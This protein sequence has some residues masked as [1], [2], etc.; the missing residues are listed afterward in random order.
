M[1]MILTLL[2]LDHFVRFPEGKAKKHM[3]DVGKNVTEFKKDKRNTYGFLKPETT[4]ATYIVAQMARTNP[5]PVTTA[6]MRKS[7]LLSSSSFLNISIITS[8]NAQ[9]VRVTVRTSLV[10]EHLP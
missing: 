9:D 4:C 5:T 8:K 1:S 3:S 7:N 2:S 10:T 6:I